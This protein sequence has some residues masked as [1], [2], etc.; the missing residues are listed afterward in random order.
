MLFATSWPVA[1]KYVYVTMSTRDCCLELPSIPT[2][3]MPRVRK[4]QSI[5]RLRERRCSIIYMW[6][7][8]L[9]EVVVFICAVFM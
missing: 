7:G 6:F 8:W 3:R 4:P 5:S 1:L 9:V 2:Y